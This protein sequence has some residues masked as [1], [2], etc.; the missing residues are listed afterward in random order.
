VLLSTLLA[1]F[2]DWRFGRVDP[3]AR[4]GPRGEQT[5][6]RFLR[7][8]GYTVIAESES[9]FA[10]EIDLICTN[11]SRSLMIF[12]EVK[13]LETTKP[14]HPADRVDDAK[15]ARVTRAAL[16]YLTRRKM[17]NCR[18]RFDVIAIWWPN[19]LSEPKKI[20]HY[21]SAFDA[22]GVDGFYS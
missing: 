19:G 2:N 13:T 14:G 15:Q 4:P 3:N 6:A 22:T 11:R 20:E 8:R 7:R 5:A 9:D 16:R 17:L 10:G 18:V 21:Q 12:V 1:R